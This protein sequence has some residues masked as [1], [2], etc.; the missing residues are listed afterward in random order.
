MAIEFRCTQCSKLLRVADDTVGKKAQCPECGEV[1]T[2]PEPPLVQP[3]APPH[4]DADSASPYQYQ[5]PISAPAMPI[6]QGTLDLGDIFDRAWLLFKANW[7][8]CVVPALIVVILNAGV[9][10]LA[11][12]LPIIGHI[13][14]FLFSLWLGIGLA[15]FFL[16]KARGQA[17]ELG[18]IF[19]GWPYFVN[20]LIATILLLL[21]NSGIVFACLLPAVIVALLLSHVVAMPLVIVGGI[22]A[23]G[24]A[25]WVSLA[26]SQ[27]RYLILDRDVDP[28]DAL[29]MSQRLMDGNKLTLFLIGLVSSVLGTAIFLFTCGLGIFLI[30]P[31]FGLMQ[32]VI[33]LT[34][35]GQP[36]AEQ[37]QSDMAQR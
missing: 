17:V 21:I 13:I 34:V 11:A 16:K 22:V 10:F 1:M 7:A 32:A 20:I 14:S 24:L 15:L 37:L 6:S 12:A 18:E 33:Y 8:E 31:F 9:G 23:F 3:A 2:I 27:Y 19:N 30:I 35:T 25:C 28:I 26:F 36:T 4:E 29:K 5:S